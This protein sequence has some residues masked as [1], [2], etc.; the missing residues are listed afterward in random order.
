M[1]DM[2]TTTTTTRSRRAV[3]G[4]LIG[5]IGAWVAGGLGGRDPAARADNG[6]NFVLGQSN[7]CT[8]SGTSVSNL[9]TAD[10]A[11]VQNTTGVWGS[12]VVSDGFGVQGHAIGTRGTAVRGFTSGHWSQVAVD[13]NV[14]A[15]NGEGYAVR[16]RTKNGTALY[17]SAAGGYALEVH[18]LAVFSRSGKATVRQG[19]ASKTI[20]GH[21]IGAGSLVV[22]TIQGNVPGTYVRGVTLNAGASSFTIRLNKAA[23][24]TLRVGWFLVN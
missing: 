6:D 17:G 8:T 14:T 5:G 20:S 22:A 3:L 21:P 13:A 9:E 12:S 23:P 4:A 16:A 10:A 7:T 2:A 1:C 11:F 18:G 19:Q 15:G 24:F